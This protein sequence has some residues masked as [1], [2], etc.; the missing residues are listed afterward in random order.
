[1][2]EEAAPRR[3]VLPLVVALGLCSFASQITFRAPDPFLPTIATEFGVSVAAAAALAAAF[4]LPYGIAQPIFGPLGDSF[5]KTLLIRVS[6]ALLSVCLFLSALSVSFPMLFGTRILTGICAGGIIPAAIAIIGDRVPLAERPIAL[7]QLMTANF[8]GQLAGPAFGGMLGAAFGWRIVFVIVGMIVSVAALISLFSLKPRQSVEREP[9]SIN[10]ARGRYAAIFANPLARPLYLLTLVEGT[11]FFGVPA[12]VAIILHD[13]EGAGSFQAGIVIACYGV[14]G[15][16]CTL[17]ARWIVPRFG[18]RTLSKAGPAIAAAGLFGFAVSF[19][20]PISAFLFVI[21]GFG[22]VMFHINM[23]TMAT[24]LTS[25]SRGS[26]IA[27]FALFLFIGQA[28]GPILFG[29]TRSVIGDIA[30]ISLNAT[31]VAVLGLYTARRIFPKVVRSQEP[32]G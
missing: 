3:P 4:A 16:I 23:Q 17:L 20:W 31:L 10:M 22:F 15:L 32:R 26:A 28:A 1:M 6:I 29:L 7:A 9:F 18:H 13:R 2:A 14:G 11:L 5:G 8:M 24:E 27:L 12:Y 25:Q 30:A 21:T 19:W